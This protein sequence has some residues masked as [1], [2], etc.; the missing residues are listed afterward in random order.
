MSVIGLGKRVSGNDGY[1]WLR[2]VN[3]SFPIYSR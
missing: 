1:Y 3:K 2:N